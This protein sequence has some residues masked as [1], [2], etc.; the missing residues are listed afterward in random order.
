MLGDFQRKL[1]AMKAINNKNVKLSPSAVAAV[2]DAASEEFTPQ[3]QEGMA[4]I[5]M[6][7]T[8]E[9]KDLMAALTA[10]VIRKLESNGTVDKIHRE[11]R[12]EREEDNNEF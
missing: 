2:Y 11:T 8:D 1:N 3:E 12:G 9:E 6:K 10:R 4:R 7:L 5:L